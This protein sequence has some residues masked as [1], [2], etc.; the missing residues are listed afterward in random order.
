[1]RSA[2][3]FGYYGYGNLGDELLCES[4]LDILGRTFDKIYILVPKHKI[5]DYT[6]KGVEP[7]NRFDFI[8]ILTTVLHSKVVVCGGGGIFQDQTSLRSFLYYASIVIVSTLFRK[9]VVLLAN[10]LGP[11]KRKF[12]RKILRYI[13][14]RKNVYFIARDPVS[15]RY[16][17]LMSQNIFEGTDLAIKS[18]SK[19]PLE[20][21]K[22][23]QVSFCLKEEINLSNILSF[24]KNIGLKRFLL[25]PMS[26]QDEKV[27]VKLMEK[28]PELEF[29]KKPLEAITCSSLVI[30][31]RMHGSLIAAY[32]GIP[33]VSVDNS[34]ASRFMKKYLPDYPGYT[35][36]ADTNIITAIS[37]VINMPVSVDKKMLEDA[38]EMEEKLIKLIRNLQR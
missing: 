30:S 33:F 12:S 13:L 27:C 20:V 6:K 17:K 14:S 21:K 31:Q 32:Y 28:Y 8:S 22:S 15:A 29:S 3:L 35:S 16:G 19:L 36:K 7:V 24:L 37:K 1:L 10:S 38:K 9:P 18:L 5:E 23:S 11:V 25:V 2:L 34:K 4:A 26:P